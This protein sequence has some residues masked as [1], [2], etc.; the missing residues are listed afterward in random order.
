MKRI[1]P[2]LLASL[3]LMIAIPAAASAH[4][5]DRDQGRGYGQSD[6]D[7][8]SPGFDQFRQQIDHLYN[9][10]E[11]GLSDGSYSRGEARQFYRSISSIRQRLDWYRRNSGYLSPQK[12][13]D[14]ERR[15]DQLHSVM[16]E[17]HE[18]GH[19]QQSYG[20]DGRRY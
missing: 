16:H 2:A 20:Y 14:I 18:D 9:G 3:A 4:E 11:H 12:S 5:H 10:V 1:V 19:D 15:L 13:A 17:A 7:R 6:W 8:E